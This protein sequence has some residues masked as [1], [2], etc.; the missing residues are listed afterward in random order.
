MSLFASFKISENAFSVLARTSYCQN[1]LTK[2]IITMTRQTLKESKPDV[3]GKAVNR[4]IQRAIIKT[5]FSME[6]RR[7]NSAKSPPENKSVSRG[8]MSNITKIMAA[9][10][11]AN[12][13]FNSVRYFFNFV[14]F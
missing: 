2:I 7:A 8:R 13:I 1:H 14:A 3:K 5:D 6:L 4:G 9:S 12:T 10:W 11:T